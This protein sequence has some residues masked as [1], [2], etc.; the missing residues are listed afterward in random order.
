MSFPSSVGSEQYS[1]QCTRNLMTEKRSGRSFH[2]SYLYMYIDGGF[3]Y[4]LS[5][6]KQTKCSKGFVLFCFVLIQTLLGGLKGLCR[7]KKTQILSSW[8]KPPFEAPQI[9]L[10]PRCSKGSIYIVV[11]N[12]DRVM[13]FEASRKNRLQTVFTVKRRWFDSSSLLMI[14]TYLCNHKKNW[15]LWKM[16]L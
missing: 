8:T 6:I 9:H 4:G 1:E 2:D 7:T 14:A 15:S 10:P 5:T 13:A 12:A 11:D 16:A 3:F